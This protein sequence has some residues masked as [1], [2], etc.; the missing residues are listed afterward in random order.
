MTVTVVNYGQT[1]T[2]ITALS[3]D[4]VKVYGIVSSTTV[5]GGTVEVYAGGSGYGTTLGN[6]GTEYVYSGGTA[7]GT[8][9]NTGGTELSTPA[10]PP[11]ARP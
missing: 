4:D 2:D 11:S 9:V 5:N 1:S 7:S 10:A 8:T 3:G 6:L